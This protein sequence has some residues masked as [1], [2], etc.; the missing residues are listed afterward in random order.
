MSDKDK[1]DV[2]RD[3]KDTEQGS[4]LQDNQ[5]DEA[6]GNKEEQKED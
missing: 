1:K 6:K 5:M 4:Q 2:I 3:P